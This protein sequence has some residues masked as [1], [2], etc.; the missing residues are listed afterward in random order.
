MVEVLRQGVLNYAAVCYACV[1]ELMVTL[2][3]VKKA[4]VLIVVLHHINL[5]HSDST[6]VI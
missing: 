1:S 4:I 6:V 3:M 5:K 2:V